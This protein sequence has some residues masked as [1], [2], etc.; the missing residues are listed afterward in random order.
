[1]HQVAIHSSLKVPAVHLART[2]KVDLVRLYRKLLEV[3]GVRPFTFGKEHQVVKRVAVR[4]VQVVVMLFQVGAKALDQQVPLG[5]L[6]NGA[7]VVNRKRYLGHNFSF[8][9][10]QKY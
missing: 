5:A 2:H 8:F 6:I 3:D 7:D 1:M 4:G 10:Q 9:A